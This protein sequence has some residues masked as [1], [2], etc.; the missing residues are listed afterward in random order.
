MRYV[1][2]AGSV[3][4]LF[5]SGCSLFSV[6]N[7]DEYNDLKPIEVSTYLPENREMSKEQPVSLLL[8]QNNKEIENAD[9]HIEI[10]SEDH[11]QHDTLPVTNKG[12]GIYEADV[13]WETEGIYYMRSEVSAGESAANPVVML[14]VG[15]LTEEEELQIENGDEGSATIEGHH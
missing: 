4:L 1:L 5:L 14:G 10:W 15:D 11:F 9:V 12:G 7:H 6:D 2:L 8:T 13:Y 3:S